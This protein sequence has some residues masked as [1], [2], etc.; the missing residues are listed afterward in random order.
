MT[1]SSRI[2][3]VVAL[4]ISL[5]AGVI[6]LALTV[7]SALQPPIQSCGNLSKDYAPIIA[8]ELARS[9]YDLE[10]IFGRP[11]SAC[12]P[13]VI[14]ALD[15]INWIDVYAFIPLYGA[16]MIFFF[17]GMRDRDARLARLGVWISV[18]AVLG[19]HAENTCLMNLTPELD[20]SSVWLSLLPWATGVKWIGL[21]VAAG[22]AALIFSRAPDRRAWHIIAA[23]GCFA[24]LLISIAA[25][26]SPIAFGPVLSTGIGVSWVLFLVTAFI[27]LV[28]GKPKL[29]PAS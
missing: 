12:R 24:S 14:A 4:R 28:G 23:L 7:L 21:G 22:V 19:D 2:S 18:L 16:F 8:F 29:A 20:A 17:L 6:I 10:A 26:V 13:G 3:S 9:A 25:M 11:D 1:T 15:S 27:E 5:A